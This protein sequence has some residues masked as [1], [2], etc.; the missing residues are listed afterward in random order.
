M[1]R[2]RVCRPGRTRAQL[3]RTEEREAMLIRAADQMRDRLEERGRTL[4]S[5]A[6]AAREAIN[7]GHFAGRR[8]AL[9]NILEIAEN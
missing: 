1:H 5:I 4:D 3:A 7:L 6:E 2:R 8:A 9:E